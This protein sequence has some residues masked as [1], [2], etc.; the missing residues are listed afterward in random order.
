MQGRCVMHDAHHSEWQPGWR[1]GTLLA[2]A[3]A[4]AYT[5]RITPSRRVRKGWRPVLVAV[6]CVA[7]LAGRAWL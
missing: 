2:I 6:A 4:S 3:Q 7:I 1:T 5:P